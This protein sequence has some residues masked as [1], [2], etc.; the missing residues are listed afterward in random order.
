MN[1][2]YHSLVNILCYG[3]FKVPAARRPS[4]QSN[5]VVIFISTRCFDFFSLFPWIALKRSRKVAVIQVPTTRRPQQRQNGVERLL[6]TYGYVKSRVKNCSVT[7]RRHQQRQNW[8]GK[9]PL[10]IDSV[11]REWKIARLQHGVKTKITTRFI[12]C[13]VGLKVENKLKSSELSVAL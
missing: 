2:W 13:E 12:C 1:K 3:R 9:T 6:Y 7:T 4:Q 10:L 5:R 11:K 8:V